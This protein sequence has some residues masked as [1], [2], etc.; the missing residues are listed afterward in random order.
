MSASSPDEAALV[1]AAAHFGYDFVDR[2]PGGI[3]QL[4]DRSTSSE[5]SYEVRPPLARIPALC[6]SPPCAPRAAPS[7]ALPCVQVLDVLEFS[8]A[9]R[10][11]SVV[12][13][14]NTS[15]GLRLLTKGADSVMLKLLGDGQA[16][17]VAATERIMEEHSNEGLRCLVIGA[18]DLEPSSYLEWS[19]R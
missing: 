17:L 16:P 6:A 14:D 12:V 10:R 9:R 5:L 4:A 15:G 13:R 2:L 8:S 19:G 18:R 7:R 11:M 1:A 3:V